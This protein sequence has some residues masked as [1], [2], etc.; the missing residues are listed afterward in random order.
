MLHIERHARGSQ[1]LRDIKMPLLQTQTLLFENWVDTNMHPQEEAHINAPN[2]PQAFITIESCFK[3][4]D[5]IAAKLEP[6]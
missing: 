3:E 4:V 1:G 6:I 5:R 2:L